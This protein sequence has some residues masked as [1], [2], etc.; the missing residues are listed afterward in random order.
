MFPRVKMKGVHYVAVCERIA[1][2]GG[3]QLGPVWRAYYYCSIRVNRAYARNYVIG[4]CT[5]LVPC[6]AIWFIT[7]FI[8]H[9]RLSLVRICHCLPKLARVCYVCVRVAVREYVPVNKS[10]HSAR[11]YLV[12]HGIYPVAPV[13][14][15]CL[16]SVRLNIH[17]NPEYIRPHIICSIVQCR[18]V[19]AVQQPLGPV[20]AHPAQ[21]YGIAAGIYKLQPLN[22]KLTI[23]RN[24]GRVNR[25][26]KQYKR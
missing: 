20:T 7:Y 19:I 1:Y 15:I 23:N 18:V 14:R 26:R 11:A 8:K 21:L 17:R 24:R 3:T 6:N 25:Y 9:M 5:Y 12:N 4:I 13:G 2:H 16:I 10:V 22:T